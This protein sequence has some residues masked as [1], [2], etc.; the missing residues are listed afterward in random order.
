MRRLSLVIGALALFRSEPA[1]AW[2][3]PDTPAAK[4]ESPRLAKAPLNTH[5]RVRFSEKPSKA[6]LAEIT[7]RS[8]DGKTVSFRATELPEHVAPSAR[9]FRPPFLME[10]VPLRPL[11]PNARYEL[12]WKMSERAERVFPPPWEGHVLGIGSFETGSRADTAAPVMPASLNSV[13]VDRGFVLHTYKSDDPVPVTSRLKAWPQGLVRIESV[14]DDLTPKDEIYYWAWRVG[15]EQTAFLLTQPRFGT[16]VL[17]VGDGEPPYECE[18]GYQFPFPKQERRFLIAVVAVDLA[19][20]LSE[21][22][23]VVLDRRQQKR[24]VPKDFTD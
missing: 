10:L 23:Y 15:A 2:A 5:L 12:S 4:L 18:T 11:E 9:D 19:G 8:A 22:R 20:N 24:V 21:I 7:L 6:D 16:R 3:C 17:A 1:H 13:F 14:S